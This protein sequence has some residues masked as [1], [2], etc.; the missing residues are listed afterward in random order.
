VN[1]KTSGKTLRFKL[2]MPCWVGYNSATIPWFIS[3]FDQV[4]RK[5]AS[6]VPDT[7]GLSFLSILIKRLEGLGLFFQTAPT[8][9]YNGQSAGLTIGGLHRKNPLGFGGG[10]LGTADKLEMNQMIGKTGGI[11]SGSW[12]EIRGSFRWV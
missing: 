4:T 2:H 8:N 1:R 7:S 3:C 9:S 5:P 11:F 6:L 12:S 10:S